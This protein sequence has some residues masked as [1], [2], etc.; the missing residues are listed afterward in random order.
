MLG[1]DLRLVPYALRVGQ[2]ARRLLRFNVGLAIALKLSL[3]IGAVLGT[4]SLLV[5]VLL[6]DL[7]ASLA[8]TINAMRIARLKV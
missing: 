6:G 3:A 4:V 8:V 1:D 7:G 5:A 2:R